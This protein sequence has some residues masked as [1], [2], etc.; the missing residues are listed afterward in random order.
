MKKNGKEVVLIIN[1][2]I[3]D[4]TKKFKFSRGEE[5]GEMTEISS[6]E[7]E[8]KYNQKADKTKHYYYEV[9]TVKLNEKSTMAIAKRLGSKDDEKNEEKNDKKITIVKSNSSASIAPETII[10]LN[11][12]MISKAE[13]DKIDANKIK[14]VDV[15]K[16]KSNGEIRIETSYNYTNNDPEIL[17]DNKVISKD[18][19]DKIETKTIKSI[20]VKKE[21]SNLKNRMVSNIVNL[22]DDAE[23]LLDNKVISYEDL[24]KLDKNEIESINIKN[25]NGK[26]SIIVKSRS[27]NKKK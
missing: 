22:I 17:L 7:F 2:K 1:G 27:K 3:K 8:K 18:G 11:D 19:M 23:I 9:E 21:K 4:V 24:N 12:K 5:L 15:K 13:M 16:G 6:E 25:K 10:Y 20:D 26:Q 14:S